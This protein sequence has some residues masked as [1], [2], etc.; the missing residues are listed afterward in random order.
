MYPAIAILVWQTQLHLNCTLE[1]SISDASTMSAVGQTVLSVLIIAV[2]SVHV[3]VAEFEFSIAI[4]W[5]TPSYTT[6]IA[7]GDFLL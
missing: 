3:L 6:W 5:L 1:F 7:S 4:V 2:H